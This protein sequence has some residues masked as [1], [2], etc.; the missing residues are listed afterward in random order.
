MLVIHKITKQL[1]EVDNPESYLASGS[2]EVY[3]DKEVEGVY[4]NFAKSELK[5]INSMLE[6]DKT[7]QKI[8]VT[9]TDDLI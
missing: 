9:F 3:Q 8:D 4:K 7:A 2:W 1:R 5:K 6:I